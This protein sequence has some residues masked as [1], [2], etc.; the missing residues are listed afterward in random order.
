MAE[1]DLERQLDRYRNA[2]GGLSEGVVLRD[3]GGR[4]LAAN[5][6]IEEV[7]GKRPE[8][9]IGLAMSDPLWQAVREDG[10]PWPP[11]EYPAVRALATSE[12]LSVLSLGPS[13]PVS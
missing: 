4:V 13:D 1:P 7:V 9:L 10:S 8:E 2:L 6:R 11:D 3:A 12:P 5:A